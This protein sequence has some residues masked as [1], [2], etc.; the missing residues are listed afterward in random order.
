MKRLGD[1]NPRNEGTMKWL[2][3]ARAFKGE[4]GKLNRDE[5]HDLETWL[6][7]GPGLF[8]ITGRPGS[9]KSTAMRFIYENAKRFHSIRH[10]S[11]TQTINDPV[12]QT[13][14]DSSDSMIL[15][16][17]H[18]S[19][20]DCCL[21][22]LFITDRGAQEQ[23]RWEPMLHGILLQLLKAQPA[24]LRYL[25]A[26]MVKKR[27]QMRPSIDNMVRTPGMMEQEIPEWS[28]SSVMEALM[29]CKKQN[30]RP[31]RALITVDGLDELESME[32]CKGMVKF[33]K[34]L[35]DDSGE[36]SNTFRICLSSR[37]EEVFRILF[38]DTWRIEIHRHTEDDIRYFTWSQLST[39]SRFTG[40]KLDDVFDQLAHV[41]DYVGTNAQGVF[42]WARSVV[43]VIFEALEGSEPLKNIP[44]LLQ[45]LPT[46][47]KE[48]YRY[49][50]R[51]IEPELRQRAF[52]ML[53]VVLRS[54][55]PV[56]LLEL[57]LIVEATEGQINGRPNIWSAT[58]ELRLPDI[59]DFTE[60]L[61]LQG[62]LIATCK[63]LLE[64][65]TEYD[66]DNPDYWSCKRRYELRSREFWVSRHEYL[67]LG[68]RDETD[69]SSP[70]PSIWS[71]SSGSGE[72]GTYESDEGQLLE[73]VS[74][75]Q[76][77]NYHDEPSLDPSRAVIRLLHRSAK[78]VL[79][80][81]NFLDTL[82]H[83]DCVERK[84]PGN[85]HCYFLLFAREWLQ[86]PQKVQQQLRCR[87]D[88][89]AET[90]YHAA[91][92]EATISDP[93]PYF[94]VLDDID[95][96]AKI[97]LPDRDRWPMAWYRD[98]GGV[99]LEPH[100]HLTFPAIAVAMDMR[101][102]MEHCIRKAELEGPEELNHFL[103]GKEGR[104]LLHFSVYM[105]LAT[106]KPEMTKFLVD[107]GV[108]LNLKFEGKTAIES[109]ILNYQSH[110]HLQVM[111]YLVKAGADPNSRHYPD[112]GRLST[113]HPLLHIVADGFYRMDLKR[114][115]EFMRLLYASRA[116]LNATD[117]LGHTFL[118]K[119]YW[120]WLKLPQDEWS[121]LL[122]KG[123]KITKSMVSRDLREA[124]PG[125]RG[126]KGFTG[127]CD[128]RGRQ[129]AFLIL[130]QPR[131]RRRD[132]Y[133]DDAADAALSLI[134][135]WFTG[136]PTAGNDRTPS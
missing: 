56:T 101:G 102:Y 21:I 134:P 29:H 89:V 87:F 42:L 98:Q 111:E 64:V 70:E 97:T 72:E 96:Q 92:L 119:L 45:Q 65:A 103:N 35:S 58:S 135:T 20:N 4:N 33:L 30:L 41:L 82:F 13:S 6:D 99:G 24:L 118:E 32:D 31:F 27:V 17:R 91:L 53:E 11:N 75:E 61:R 51:R 126:E 81:A 93:A 84:P 105:P 123:A 133:H 128:G 48:L 71:I 25:F 131:F 122:R 121:W 116:D 40:M 19:N 77:R 3:R 34:Q 108:D 107:K 94:E 49:I 120:G 117:Y 26:Y 28:P 50:L 23:R 16:T 113:W 1:I 46:E 66:D 88:P 114:R 78:E 37:S 36:S 55:R 90:I 109:L 22:G 8:W 129:D 43:N 73:M 136:S 59:K 69:S 110:D 68:N 112:G 60:P 83:E 52:I 125:L 124:H 79:L 74:R 47:T 115:I 67:A 7:H 106:P 10:S 44:S 104:P 2:H 130:H 95:I 39:S 15:A 62:Q 85:G 127:L 18:H 63:C 14:E 12:R 80:D 57:L 132:W 54:R 5:F 86:I 38:Q 76:Y 9:G 100:W